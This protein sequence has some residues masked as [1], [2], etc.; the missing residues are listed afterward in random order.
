VQAGSDVDSDATTE[1]EEDYEPASNNTALSKEQQYLHDLSEQLFA[2]HKSGIAKPAPAGQPEVW[3][4]GRQELCET[5]HYFRSYQSACY[6]TGGFVR[7]FMFD[8]VAHVRDYVDSNVVISRAG[9]GLIKDTNC[10][11]PEELHEALQ[12][13]RCNYRYR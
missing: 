8:K 7:G 6:S 10:A 12:S 3:A 13:C 1:D 5:L 11:S 9:G 4:D 2:N